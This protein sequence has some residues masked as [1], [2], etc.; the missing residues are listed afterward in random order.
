ME[1]HELAR[2][3]KAKAAAAAA[4]TAAWY[5]SDAIA[6]LSLCCAARLALNLKAVTQ[7]KCVSRGSPLIVRRRTAL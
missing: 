7:G 5:G 1:C 2:L 4:A 6:P 3:F